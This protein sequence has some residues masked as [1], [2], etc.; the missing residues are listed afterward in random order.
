MYV[1]VFPMADVYL[2]RH[3]TN[4]DYFSNQ[5]DKITATSKSRLKKYVR[6]TCML[7]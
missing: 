5:Y 1:Y 3:L 7:A 6:T 2:G 4:N